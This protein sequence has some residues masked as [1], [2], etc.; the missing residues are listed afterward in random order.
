MAA[1]EVTVNPDTLV[2]TIKIIQADPVVEVADQ[3]LE[4]GDPTFLSLGD[5]IVTFHGTNGDV[6]Y[7]LTCH[8]DLHERWI[9]I[10]S[11]VTDEDLDSA[12]A[13]EG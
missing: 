1:F 4:Y 11:D 13:R 7:G 2:R 10:R 3:V 5:G 8:D 12:Y 9:G 6:S